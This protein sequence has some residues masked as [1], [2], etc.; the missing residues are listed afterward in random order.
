LAWPTKRAMSSRASSPST[1]RVVT[2]VRQPACVPR[3]NGIA[4]GPRGLLHQLGDGLAQHQASRRRGEDEIHLFTV[5]GVGFPDR[6][7]RPLSG[8][9]FEAP[10]QERQDRR[11]QP[12]LAAGALRLRRP[13]LLTPAIDVDRGPPHA[14]GPRVEI[15]VFPG[16]PEHFGDPPTLEEEERHCCSQPVIRDGREERPG[17]SMSSAAPADS[18]TRTG[19]TARTGLPT[20]APIFTVSSTICASVCR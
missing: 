20:S 1:N 5:V 4:G 6:G 19:F 15:E 2:T 13:E 9:G 10:R 14:G 12:V 7:C 16:E 17:W 3:S 11:H 8:L 18:A